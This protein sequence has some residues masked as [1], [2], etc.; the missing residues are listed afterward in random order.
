[1]TLEQRPER[2]VPLETHFAMER[3]LVTEASLLDALRF[4]EWLTMLSPTIHY[5][6]PVR[7]NR[8]YR[9]RAL[10]TSTPGSSAYFD[11]KYADLAQRVDRFNTHMAW[12]EDPPSRTRH[13]I[14]NI[15]V[16]YGD[17]PELFKV[18]SNFMVYRTRTERDEN[19][20]A[21]R[22]E[23]IIERNA[24]APYG[25]QVCRRTVVFDMATLLTPNISGFF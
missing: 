25:F 15:S 11:E 18:A 16:E 1:M 23:D 12:S 3:F 20:L 10:E 21:G 4:D 24:Q 9:E 2:T 22:R 14:T 6:A 17:E 8:L 13:F 7:S 19:T 5:W